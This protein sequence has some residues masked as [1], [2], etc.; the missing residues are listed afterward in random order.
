MKR[1]IPDARRGLTLLELLIAL[2]ILGAIMGSVTAI[3]AQARGW[4]E[5]A[6]RHHEVFRLQR[7]LDTLDT[8]WERR[9]RLAVQDDLH[10][11]VEHGPRHLAFVTAEPLLFP[12]WPLVRATYRI[13]VVRGDDPSSWTARLVY[14]E[15]RVDEPGVMPPEFSPLIDDASRERSG[16]TVLLEGVTG[17]RFERFGTLTGEQESALERPPEDADERSRSRDERDDEDEVDEERALRWRVYDS[18]IDETI[19]ALRL[20]GVHDGEAFTCL[21]VIAGSR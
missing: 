18:E 21:F 6:E 4:T 19:D 5:D 17:L 3:W 12:D 20:A 13:D 10:T 2:A 14:A 1:A 8:Q 15:T 11:G 9:V 7:A 16:E